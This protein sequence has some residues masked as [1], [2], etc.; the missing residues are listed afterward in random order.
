MRST[1]RPLLEAH[2]F[3]FLQVRHFSKLYF[4]SFVHIQIGLQM[5]STIRR[6]PGPQYLS[7]LQV[8]HFCKAP[9]SGSHQNFILGHLLTPKERSRG[10]K[11]ARLYAPFQGHSVSVSCKE[12]IFAK[13]QPTALTITLFQVISSQEA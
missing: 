4:R 12:G 2:C 7:F 13:A 1:I 11:C 8:G 9:N 5:C 10:S 3:R 6:L